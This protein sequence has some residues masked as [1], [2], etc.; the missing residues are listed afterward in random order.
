MRHRFLTAAFLLASARLA[1]QST[2]STPHTPPQVFLERAYFSFLTP[3][4]K[5]L[6]F[7]GQPTVHYFFYNK[8]GDEGW[9]ADG[10]WAFAVPLTSAFQVRMTK[11]GVLLQ[12]GEKSSSEPVLTPSYRI[13][14]RPQAFYLWH[15]AGEDHYRLLGITAGFTHYSNGQHGC[16][17]IGFT[18]DSLG[19]CT[20]NGPLANQS[21]ANV[22]DGDF[23]TSYFSEAVDYRWAKQTSTFGT[24]KYL[25][26]AG[27]EFKQDPLNIRPGGTNAEQAKQYGQGE[28]DLRAEGEA[29]RLGR[30]SGIGRLSANLAHRYGGGMTSSLNGEQIEAAYLFDCLGEAGVFVRAHWG[31]DYYNIH[32]QEKASFWN[33]GLVWDLGRLDHLNANNKH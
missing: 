29:R 4:G 8:L 27:I 22:V 23:S 31:F 21:I 3:S 26:N 5:H 17:Y 18:R 10:G 14:V 32:F 11:D 6:L 15:G 28:I 19:N 16:T 13:G 24:T 12:N 33:V 2:D 9:Q 20:G 30:A 1:A 7:E 25:V